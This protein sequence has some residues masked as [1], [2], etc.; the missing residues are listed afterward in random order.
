MTTIVTE[1]PHDCTIKVWHGE[2]WFDA[3]PQLVDPVTGEPYDVTDVLFELVVRPSFD[4]DTRLVLI[5][6]AGASGS[7]IIKQ[8]PALGLINIFM[9]K[10]RVEAELPVTNSHGWQ[11]FLRM[12][13]VDAELGSMRKHLWTGTIIVFPARDDA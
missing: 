5:S 6:S 9:P 3:I 7:R 10:A 2:D 1:R 8:T 4:H 11:Q 13:W 12:T